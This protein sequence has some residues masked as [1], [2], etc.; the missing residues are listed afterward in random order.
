M[1][2]KS[3]TAVDEIYWAKGSFMRL[4]YFTVNGYYNVEKSIKTVNACFRWFGKQCSLVFK[5]VYCSI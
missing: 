1:K 5:V 2:L 4:V 3:I